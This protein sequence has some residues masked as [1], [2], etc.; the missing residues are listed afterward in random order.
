MLRHP[1]GTTLPRRLGTII[2]ALVGTGFFF[3][4]SSVC[5]VADDGDLPSVVDPRVLYA[6]SLAQ[7]RSRRLLPYEAFTIRYE[8]FM[9]R[10]LEFE[11]SRKECGNDRIR[12]AHAER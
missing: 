6:R 9:I 5:S 3:A 8:A 1:A 11:F 10:C 4:V 2:A 7:W 12:S